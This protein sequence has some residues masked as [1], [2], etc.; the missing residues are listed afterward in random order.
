MTDHSSEQL[1]RLFSVTLAQLLA[2]DSLTLS[3]ETRREDVDD[4]D[5]L[6]YVNFIVALEMELNVQFQ[7]ADVEAFETVGEIVLVTQNLLGQS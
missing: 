1:L 4:W 3:M 7:I 6:A 2:N 5:S